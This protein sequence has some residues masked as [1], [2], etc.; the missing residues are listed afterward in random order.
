MD[1][2]ESKRIVAEMPIDDEVAELDRISAQKAV[3]Y[4]KLTDW[5]TALSGLDKVEMAWHIRISSLN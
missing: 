2:D 4:D 1:D 5:H 3:L